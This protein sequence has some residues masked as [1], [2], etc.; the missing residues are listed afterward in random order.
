[1]TEPLKVAV[2]GMG[3]F[4]QTHHDTVL[5]LEEE[6]ECRLVCTCDPEMAGFTERQAQLRFAERGVQVYTDYLAMLDAHQDSLDLVTIPT[7]VPLHAPM[8]AACVERGLAVYLEKPPTLDYAELERMIALEQGARYETMVGFNFIVEPQRQA[9]KVRLVRGDFGAVRK[10]GVTGLWPRSS[11]YYGRASWAGRLRLGGRVVLDSCL[12]NG[13]AHYAHNGL[14]WGGTD[15]LWQW[16]SLRTVAAEL[17]RAH[18]IEGTDTVFVRAQLSQGPE[19]LVGMT[20][21]CDGETDERE[22]AECE[23]AT[24]MQRWVSLPEG[25]RNK[26]FFVNWTDGRVEQELNATEQ[27]TLENFRTYLRYLRGEAPRPLTLLADSR[28]FVQ[29]NDLAYIA[30]GNITQVPESALRRRTTT[31]ERPETFVEIA[32]IQEALACFMETGTFP[33]EQGLPWA[34]PGGKASV[35]DLPRLEEVIAGM[36]ASAPPDFKSTQ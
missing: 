9:L 3:G 21:A 2:I 5:A 32:G 19:L 4:A 8:H 7:P 13:M 28:P 22:W 34:A 18:P 24:I 35:E 23:Q 12:G 31:G 16:G 17:Y 26:A 36:A 29:L 14:F 6:G 15:D 1:M 33:S 10:I 30:A 27:H 25:G 20:H 11:A